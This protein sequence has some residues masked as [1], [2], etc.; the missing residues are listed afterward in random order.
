MNPGWRRLGAAL[1]GAH[2]FLPLPGR[3]RAAPWRGEMEAH[4]RSAKA[5]TSA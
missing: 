1:P 4:R 2:V 3:Q 5:A